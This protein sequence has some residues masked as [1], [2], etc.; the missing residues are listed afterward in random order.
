M[1]PLTLLERKRNPKKG[2]RRTDR[3]VSIVQ[4]KKEIKGVFLLWRKG[5]Q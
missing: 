1:T 4:E 2:N 5:L 3:D